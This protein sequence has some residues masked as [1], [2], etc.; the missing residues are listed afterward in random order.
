MKTIISINPANGEKIGETPETSV[1]EM[2]EIIKHARVSFKTWRRTSFEKRAKYLFKVID[3][4]IENK[5][6]I[7]QLT[8]KEMGKPI[9]ESRED[10]DYEIEFIDYY[11]KNAQRILGEKII[12]ED[13]RAFYKIVYE[14]WGVV[15]SIAPW[16]FPITMASSGISAQIMAGNCVIFKPSEYTT[17]SQKAFV[18]LFNQTGLPKGV[19]QCVIGG[20]DMGA[21]LI[22]SSIDFVWFTGSTKVGQEIYRKCAE[23]FIKC[24]LELGGSSPAIVFADCN[25][26]ATVETVF[27]ARFFNCGQVCSSIKRL[28]VEKSIYDQFVEALKNRMK[29]VEIGDPMD[30]KN[31][32]GPL[33][34]KKQLDSLQIQFVDAKEKGAN[35]LY[36][37]QEFKAGKMKGN[38]FEPAIVT[39]VTKEMKLYNEE[40]FGPILPV[41]PF[42]N[43]ADAIELANDTAYGLTAEIFTQDKE[44]GNRVAREINAGGV[45]IN[46]DVI[47]SPHCPIGGFKKSGIGREYGEEGVKEFAQLKYIC[48]YK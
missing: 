8:T 43:E 1:I 32:M 12:R 15:A 16:N 5:E 17:L 45:S 34:S 20:G 9:Q 11:A 6:K 36:S 4:L 38:F 35:F 48:E 29:K 22:D 47:Y 10:V 28:F 3:L 27:M 18:D 44:K 40:V 23:K 24:D 42:D 46:G 39:H 33:V 26:D 21:K 7:A 25:F 37:G 13:D 19:L 41:I 14:P 30:P 2:N 31:N